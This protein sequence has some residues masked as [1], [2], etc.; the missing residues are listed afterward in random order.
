VYRNPQFTQDA[1]ARTIRRKAKPAH[2][3]GERGPSAY[4]SIDGGPRM[5]RSVLQVRSCHGRA[6]HP[7]QKPEGIVRPILSY[8]LAPGGVLL[9]PFMGSGTGLIIAREMGARAIGIDT[10][11]QWCEIAAKRLQQSVL[12]MFAAVEVGP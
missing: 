7:T 1:T 4:Q 9:E 5:M 11:E 8:S 2:W 6:L 12:P 3:T 10:R